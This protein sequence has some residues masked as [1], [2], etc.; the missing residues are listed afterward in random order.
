VHFQE[1]Y[2]LARAGAALETITG[3]HVQGKIGVQL[4]SAS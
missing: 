3:S 1:S 4:D 2:E